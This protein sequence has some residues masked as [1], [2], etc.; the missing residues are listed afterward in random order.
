MVFTYVMVW[1]VA[2]IGYTMMIPDTIMGISFLAAGT[3]VPDAM[4]SLIVARQGKI[5]A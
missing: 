5:T 1:M 4:A 3:S 2:L